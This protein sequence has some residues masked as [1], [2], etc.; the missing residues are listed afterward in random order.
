MQV[1]IALIVAADESAVLL[2]LR[3]DH[4]AHGGL[5]ELPGGKMESDETPWQG[6]CRELKEELGIMPLNGSLI[7]ELT[8]TYP[9]YTVN[10][11]TFKVSS[12]QGQIYGREGQVCR[13]VSK[14]DLVNYPMPEGTQ[15]VLT[16]IGF[17]A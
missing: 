4:K 15:R 1:A 11:K 14:A 3:P 6:L 17:L 2:G 12:W 9:D 7:R 5:W 8:Y 10:L 13:W 16:E